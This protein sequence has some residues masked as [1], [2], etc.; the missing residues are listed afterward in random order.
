M[1]LYRADIDTDQIMPKQF[2][3][4]VERIG[5]GDV[6]FFDWRQDPG[7][8]INSPAHAGAN[9]LVTGPNFG[10]GSSREHAPWGLQQHGFEAIV[11]P[12]FGAIFATNCTKIGLL[13]VTLPARQCMELAERA[14]VNP[15]TEVE[16]DLP[17]QTI[18][19]DG[20]TARF[21]ID[22]TRKRR[23]VEGFDEIT[24]ALHDEGAITAYEARRHPWL[25][26]TVMDR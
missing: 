25:P 22:A 7:F 24:A 15:G 6:I 26:R 21:E 13:L 16:I 9:V 23:L 20:V 14:S 2:L 18:A 5:F 8:V 1:P 12:S 17:A 10:S 4:R 3:K 19:W 11:A